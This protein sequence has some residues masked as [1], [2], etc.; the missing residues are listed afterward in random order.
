[1][2]GYSS[3]QI[4]FLHEDHPFVSLG[5]IGRVGYLL[6]SSRSLRGGALLASCQEIEA[7]NGPYG[8]DVVPPERHGLLI[9]HA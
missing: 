1:M 7:S 2:G 4:P 9:T 5:A 6:V 8:N 3:R